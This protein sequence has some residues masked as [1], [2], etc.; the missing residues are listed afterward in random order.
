VGVGGTGST[1][2]LFLAGLAFHAQQKGIQVEI[3]MVDDDII[4]ANNVGRQHFAASSALMGNVP[5]CVD[6][7]ARLNAAYCLGLTAWPV[8]YEAG[9]AR[10]WFHHGANGH[11]QAHLMIG[12]VDNHFGRREIAQTVTAFDGRIWAIDSGNEQNS[13]QILIG[14]LTDTSQI[15]L[16][17]LG[18]CSG[19]PSPYVQEPDLLEPDPNTQNQSCAEMGDGTSLA[20]IQSLMVNRMA[21]TIAAEYTAVFILQRQITQLRT[22]FNLQP[23]I[24]QSQPI[25]QTVLRPYL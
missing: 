16:D 18:L 22:A 10:D 19:L 14:N 23:L 8:K 20:E 3:T 13:G 7:A 9:L 4:E 15:K 24:T 6:L 12:C 25:T 11:A 17:K 21:A 1:L 2:A 5:K